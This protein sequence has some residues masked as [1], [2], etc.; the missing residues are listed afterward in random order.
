MVVTSWP[1]LFK[2]VIFGWDVTIVVPNDDCR[3]NL[4]QIRTLAVGREHGGIGESSIA[5]PILIFE[6]HVWLRGV[7]RSMVLS[8]II[9]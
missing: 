5:R 3:M 9:P 6:V 8:S 7:Q 2:S 1:D 4:G